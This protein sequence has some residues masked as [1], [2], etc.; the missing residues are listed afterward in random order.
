[1]PRF[2]ELRDVL[3][4]ILQERP[5]CYWL[6]YQILKRLRELYPEIVEGLEERCETGYSRGGG[7]F[8]RPDNAIAHCLQDWPEC[9]DVQY[10][11]GR[12]IQVGDIRVPDEAVA[13]YRWIG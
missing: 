3:G 9:V 8:Y 13:V 5:N 6:C 11:F 12:D 1:M 2:D 4:K 10:L 7:T